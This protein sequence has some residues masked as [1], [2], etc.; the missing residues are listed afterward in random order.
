MGALLQPRLHAGAL[1]GTEY[2]LGADHRHDIVRDLGRVGLPVSNPRDAD[3]R[4]SRPYCAGLF[5][6]L[7]S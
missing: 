5:A 7:C 2:A 6:N 4:Y 3:S 1:S